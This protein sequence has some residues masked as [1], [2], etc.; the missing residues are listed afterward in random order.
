M[1]NTYIVY[2]AA[3]PTTA[4]PVKV[5]T[6]T[7]IKTMLQLKPAVPISVVEWGISFDGSAA[8]TPG[9]VCLIDAGTVFGTVTAFAAADVMTFNDPNAPAN[10]AGTAGVPL[11]LGTTHSGY[12]CTAEG[13]P[14][15]TRVLDAQLISPMNQYVKQFPL[16][17]MPKVAAGNALAVRVTMG[18]AVNA[19]TYVVFEV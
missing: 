4:A 6:G 17:E 16:G 2:N 19:L 14:T 7:A 11:N 10:T 15:A 1:A 5:T 8:A 18:A 13:T 3:M 12:T 9:N